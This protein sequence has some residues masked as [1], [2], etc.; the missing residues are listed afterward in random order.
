MSPIV[1][2]LKI[3]RVSPYSIKISASSSSLTAIFAERH[4]YYFLDY[5]D[6][7]V[8]DAGLMGNES[9]FINHS[10]D[11][12]VEVV[13]WKLADYDEYQIGLFALRDIDEKEELCYDYGW[14]AFS[15]IDTKDA[16]SSETVRDDPVKQPCLCAGPSCTGFLEKTEKMK[17]KKAVLSSKGQRKGKA[18]VSL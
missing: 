10:C 2:Q 18:T 13:R 8:V 6:A 12:N 15:S 9:R 16:E 1:A 7:E 17:E 11:P 4:D 5:Y 3:I 14:Q